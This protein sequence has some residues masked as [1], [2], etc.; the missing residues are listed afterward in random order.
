MK[1]IHKEV[2]KYNKKHN[3]S[4]LVTMAPS[5]YPWSKEEYLQD[6]PTWVNDGWVDYVFPQIYRYSLEAYEAALKDSFNFIDKDK[7][8][9]FY[10]GVL[11]G[12]GGKQTANLSIFK[13]MLETNRKYGINGEVF[14]YY[15]SLT[16]EE[17]GKIIKNEYR[18]SK[19]N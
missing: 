6:W 10:P 7:L 5:V 8:N 3:K 12:V 18:N 17:V 1:K 19:K 13:D 2:K 16:N 11:I 4:I 15:E 9:K 14:F